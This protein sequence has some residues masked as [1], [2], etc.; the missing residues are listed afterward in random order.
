VPAARHGSSA[1]L[2]KGHEVLAVASGTRSNPYWVS[3]GTVTAFD[4]YVTTTAGVVVVGLIDTGTTAGRRHSGGAVVDD[5]GRLVG[6]LTV[7]PGSPPAGLAVP[8]DTARDVAGQLALAGAAS[9]AWLGVTG[10]DETESARGGALVEQVMPHG[11]AAKAG[12]AAGDVIIAVVEGESTTSVSGMAE[13]MDEVRGRRPGQSLE[14]TVVRD[15]AKRQ[16]VIP[17]MDKTSGY[18]TDTISPTT[19]TSVPSE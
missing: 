4:Q 1:E 5:H 11:P 10:T 12:V 9:H 16:M 7:P 13:L 19:T 6:I 3:I 8:I 14:I 18:D 17:L 2:R 15:G